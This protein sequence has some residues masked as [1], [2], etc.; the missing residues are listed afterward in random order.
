MSQSTFNQSPLAVAMANVFRWGVTVKVEP[1]PG[2]SVEDSVQYHVAEY[3]RAQDEGRDVVRDEH[4][5][6]LVTA[7]TNLLRRAV[8]HTPYSHLEDAQADAVA[9]FI[10]L[11]GVA[12]PR[13]QKC[14][15]RLV[16]RVRH[17]VADRYLA[18]APLSGV[19]RAV[20]ERCRNI[21]R[22]LERIPPGDPVGYA[23]KLV[24]LCAEHCV[25]LT[26]FRDV[27]NSGALQPNDPESIGATPVG[28]DE[29][30]VADH[31]QTI[32]DEELCQWLL[33]QITT[34]APL[35]NRPPSDVRK[36]VELRCG[37]L[38]GDPGLL[39]RP[40]DLNETAGIMGMSPDAVKRAWTGGLQQMRAALAENIDNAPQAVQ[41]AYRLRDSESTGPTGRLP[42]RKVPDMQMPDAA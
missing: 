7:F 38:C 19:S 12:A 42:R 1:L 15:R 9:E 31:I 20:A 23:Q 22:R 41:D 24:A 30:A 27:I 10:R 3:Q 17:E 26:T 13:G 18:A 21:L 2:R 40:Y 33:N 25:A 28:E 37:W 32:S 8:R 35:V 29:Y 34:K 36:V 4:L 11:C 5:A 6:W 14:L 16:G 39:P